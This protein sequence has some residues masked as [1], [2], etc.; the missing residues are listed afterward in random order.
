MF[1]TLK[2]QAHAEE[3]FK[4]K[5][6]INDPI[7]IELNPN[8]YNKYINILYKAFM[9]GSDPEGKYS[10]IEKRFKK[11]INGKIVQNNKKIKIKFRITGE[12]KDHLNL[13]VPA[14]SL[15]VKIINGNFH[16]LTRFKLFLPKSREGSNEIFW[17]L[18][19]KQFG[20]PVYHTQFVNIDLNGIKYKAI[21]QEE[22][23]KEFL[24][25][26]AYRETAIFR[27][28]DLISFGTNHVTSNL[29]DIY[30]SED[31]VFLDNGNFIKNNETINI[32]SK[33]IAY[34]NL[35]KFFDRV[36]LNQF[37][38]KASS[39]Y[40]PHGKHRAN[41]KYIFNP[42][43]NSFI[44][45][46]YDG[47][48]RFF[49]N[50]NYN[51]KPVNDYKLK[52]LRSEFLKYS[53]RKLNS[54]EI[55]VFEDL[56]KIYKESFIKKD[57]FGD[58]LDLK[59][60]PK[61]TF[62][63]NEVLNFFKS[64]H[65]LSEKIDKDGLLYSL[66]YKNKF[67]LCLFQIEEKKIKSCKNLKFKEYKK[68]LSSITKAYKYKNFNNLTVYNLGTIDIEDNKIILNN[69]KES[70]ILDKK[71]LYIYKSSDKYKNINFN[72]LN[73][74]A[75]LI[76]LGKLN[77]KSF[78]FKNIS[79]YRLENKLNSRF[80]ENLLT[81]C[82]TFYKNEFKDVKINSENI[83]FCEDT[84]NI[85]NSIGNIS[86]IEISESDFDG[87]DIDASKLE[88]KKLKVINSGNDCFDLSFGEYNLSEI[89]LKNCS[90]KGISIG[91]RSIV[92]LNNFSITNANIGVATKDSSFL[93]ISN[94]KLIQN[95]EYCLAVYNKKDEFGPS[96]LKY[97]NIKCDK[98]N[99]FEKGS[100]IYD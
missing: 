18:S 70:Y 54:K 50:Q 98:K 87:L 34:R 86:S 40:A 55:C 28:N 64:D 46:Y 94:G 56:K 47:M 3:I 58:Y 27:S 83:Y 41:R 74:K 10:I 25:R 73:S 67:Y 24:E 49:F 75:R 20:L 91:E 32:V 22:S 80:N 99:Y 76:I 43:N 100:L 61:Y 71:K 14:A 21:L 35:E 44:P 62:M 88:V 65:Q 90:D 19:L 11:W 85:M 5:I 37:F 66:S 36:K 57:F 8:Q 7:K 68:Y 97:Q 79:P 12:L 39:K 9:G 42:I 16:G 6:D 45:L 52:N 53:G 84:I 30:Y 13:S 63:R 38:I 89:E 69:N 4:P 72:F 33:A 29:I 23:S 51:C 15:K 17:T 31:S 92:N 48:M 93:D 2:V 1:L 81:G 60:D 78:F 96:T 95:K 59:F 26:N 82:V 77:N